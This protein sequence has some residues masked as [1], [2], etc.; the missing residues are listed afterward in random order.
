M[1]R[2]DLLAFVGS[3]TAVSLSGCSGSPEVSEGQS[4]DQTD[5]GTDQSDDQTDDGTDQSDDQTD[6]GTDQS[7]DQTDG[8]NGI[9]DEDGEPVILS[10]PA[11]D[12]WGVESNHTENGKRINSE[13]NLEMSNNDSHG[14]TRYSTNQFDND[15]EEIEVT[16][17]IEDA[18][19]YENLKGTARVPRVT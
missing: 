5:D 10:Y 19:G 7:D 14:Q 13:G 8:E 9:N 16:V 15:G 17:T 6:D 2:R 4:D 11:K 3:A 12:D 18:D 1:N